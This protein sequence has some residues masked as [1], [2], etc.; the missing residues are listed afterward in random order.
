MSAIVILDWRPLR[1]GAVLGFAKV[2]FPS[3]MILVA[4]CVL[5]GDQGAWASPPSKPMMGRDGPV[6]DRN[7]K[8]RY[9]AMVEFNSR[10]TKDR[11]SAAVIAA[12]EEQYPEAFQ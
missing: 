12:M 6:K 11:W 3:G 7:G 1:K 5:S 8:Q 10:E 9:A 2:E 4:V